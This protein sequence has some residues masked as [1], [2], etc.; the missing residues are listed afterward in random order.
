MRTLILGIDR[1]SL[2]LREFTREK[3][4]MFF[5]FLFPVLMLALF[6]AVFSDQYGGADAAPGVNAARH[7]LP[8]MT[9]AGLLLTSFQTMAIG[10]ATERDDGTLKRLR[11]TPLPAASYFLGKV[12]MVL[13]SS[14]AQFGLLILVA[15]G[16]FRVQLP[17]DAQHW[18]TFAWTFVLG[19]GT[20]TICGIAYSSF[21][22]NSRSATPI[23][24]AP[25]L[26]LQFISGVY[27]SYPDLPR[28]LQQIAAIFPLKWIAQGERSVF[29]PDSLRSQEVAN[30]WQHVETALVLGGWSL[31]A[32][33]LALV[34][35][36]WISKRPA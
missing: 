13:V 11:G 2:E 10:V 21:I 15:W 33:V 16:L 30:S 26:I 36:R 35:F 29:L 6:S 23:V 4:A 17:T 18:V 19:V 31:A 34:T 8:A 14:V 24:V 27:F 5:V 32:L 28:W 20:G 22:P 7:F 3:E 9:A 25:A 12:G 1:T